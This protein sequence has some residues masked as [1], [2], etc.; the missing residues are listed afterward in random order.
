[1]SAPSADT[2]LDA[3][4]EDRRAR[5][6]A[7]SEF[8]RP[9]LLEAGA[10]TGKTTTLVA[11]I[12]AWCLGPGWRLHADPDTSGA[13]SAR[14]T[15]APAADE[16]AAAV[17]E[18]VVAI[19]FTEDAAAEMARRVAQELAALARLDAG[20]EPIPS[21]LHL[22]GELTGAQRS[23]RAAAL[24]ATLDRL[25]VRTIHAYCRSLLADHP[26]EARLHPDLAVDADGLLLEEVAR[27]TLEANLRRLY[28]STEDSAYLTLAGRG[29]GPRELVEALVVLSQAGLPADALDADPL[30]GGRVARLRRRLAEACCQVHDYVEPRLAAVGSRAKNAPRL[31]GAVATMLARLG[32]EDSPGADDCETDRLVDLLQVSADLFPKN[33]L[34]HLGRWQKWSMGSAE[35]DAF[36]DV[37]DELAGAAA[38]LRALLRH[39]DA[40]DPQ[41]LALAYRALA[42]LHRQVRDEM[43]ARGIVTFEDLLAEAARLLTDRADVAASIRGRIDQL[44]VDEFQDTDALQCDLVAALGLAGPQERRPGLFLVGD[45]KQSIYGWRSADLAAYDAF[46]RRVEVAG[47]EVLP[48]VENFRSVPAILDEVERAVAPIMLAS[49]GVQPPFQR[50]L[51]CERLAEDRGF[52]TS[53]EAENEN[54]PRRA[55]VE[56]W[57]SWR[58]GDDPERC[59]AATSKTHSYEVE[60][61]A[62]ARDVRHLHDAHGVP[63]D[64]FAVLLRSTTDLDLYL[65]AL[66]GHGVPFAVGRDKQYYR[67]REVIDAAALVRAVLD[68]GDHLALLTVLRSPWVGVPDAALVPL[69][70][71]GF[72]DLLHR[73]TGPDPRQL[74]E[75]R[76]V[77][78]DAAA[79]LDAL[80]P[81][82]VP[83]LGRVAGWHLSLAAGCEQLAVARQAFRELP[84]DAF[85]DTLRRL[86]LPEAV[87][88]ARYLG[89]YRLANLERF[90]RRLVTAMEDGGGDVTAVLRALRRSVTEAREAPEG[91]PREGADDAVQVMTIHQAKGLDFGHVYLPQLHKDTGGGNPATE[92]QPAPPALDGEAADDRFEIKLFGAP[93]LGFDRVEER[94]AQVEAAE[95]VRLLYVAMTRAEHRLVLSGGWGEAAPEPREPERAQHFLDLLAH[96]RDLPNPAPGHHWEAGVA[97]FA[98]AAGALWRFPART[99]WP[100]ADGVEAATVEVP[101][102]AEVAAASR[103]L[104]RRTVAARGRMERPFAA[105]ASEEAHHLLREARIDPPATVGDDPRRGATAGGDPGRGEISGTESACGERLIALTV[106]TAIHRWLERLPLETQGDP[107]GESLAELVDIAAEPGLDDA[108]RKASLAATEQL[109]E[110]ITDG[111]LLRRLRDLAPHVLGREVPILA[112]PPD[113]TSAEASAAARAPG[114]P[115]PPVAFLSGAIDLLYADPDGGGIVVADYKTDDIAGDEVEASARL[116]APQGRVYTEAIRCALGLDRPPRFELWFLRADRIVEIDP[117]AAPT[118]PP[119]SPAAERSPS[120]VPALEGR[121]GEQISLFDLS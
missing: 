86:F 2:V 94:R 1:M 118:T 103:E 100:E 84:A 104:E 115:V 91:R 99:P 53:D 45:P 112:T 72:P 29:I 24:L 50:L 78:E 62:L 16:V 4:S 117:T 7:Q 92:V 70:N 80:S 79:D 26:L 8:R 96:R 114:V 60:A 15:E 6:L 41:L 31:A 44:L 61:T 5:R 87:A 95:R 39:L 107:L 19:T 116:Y 88:A 69:W 21:W 25:V 47:G 121:P 30:S 67:R 82:D 74:D 33:L 57:V 64:R 108:G 3:R 106:G 35:Q 66:R 59:G 109:V 90:F 52:H 63:W 98:D 10:G 68:P 22:E 48:L 120:G 28:G 89:R 12:L 36:A 18:R 101:K 38:T 83:G 71:R 14:R 85:V 23:R 37:R 77:A 56:H 11:R 55:A 75:L 76:A 46:R 111:R 34:D 27:E 20:A 49:P 51:P 119:T 110:S 40:L 13:P 81:G 54:G 93:S 65:E 17:L 58:G 42:P 102:P 32:E 105:T 97:E 113:R 43:R 9:L 73:L